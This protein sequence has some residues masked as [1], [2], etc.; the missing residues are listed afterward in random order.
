MLTAKL[1]KFYLHPLKIQITKLMRFFLRHSVSELKSCIQHQQWDMEM[2][3]CTWTGNVFYK[4][5]ISVTTALL[6]VNSAHAMSKYNKINNKPSLLVG[7]LLNRARNRDCASGLRNW[8]M[9]SLALSHTYTDCHVQVYDQ[10]VVSLHSWIKHVKK[11][12][13]EKKADSCEVSVTHLRIIVIVSFLFWP[14]NGSDPVSISN[15]VQPSAFSI[16]S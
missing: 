12:R 9:P 14:W 13:W 3:C 16:I 2:M 5:F 6:C 11:R 8:G 4:L 15:C 1:N 10:H 7:F